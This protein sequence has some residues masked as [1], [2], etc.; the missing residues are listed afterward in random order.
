M[1]TREYIPSS[2]L[3]PSFVLR[4]QHAELS[5]VQF[6]D[7][8]P[9]L[10]TGSVEGSVWMWNVETRRVMHQF[11]PHGR[12]GMLTVQFMEQGNKMKVITQGRD[13]KIK[14]WD[15]EKMIEEK[16]VEGKRREEKLH[17][18]EKKA[19]IECSVM[20]RL[21]METTPLVTTIQPLS[22]IHSGCCSFC[23]FS[24][25]QLKSDLMP[26]TTNSPCFENNSNNVIRSEEI[27]SKTADSSKS[28]LSIALSQRHQPT[29]VKATPIA[30]LAS[31]SLLAVPGENACDINIW[32]LKSGK[33][34]IRCSIDQSNI[35][36][37]MCMSVKMIETSRGFPIISAGYESGHIASFQLQ[38]ASEPIMIQQFHQE[39]C[40]CIDVAEKDG[41]VSTASG[42][43]DQSMFLFEQNLQQF[44]FKNIKETKLVVAGIASLQFRP[45]MKIFVTGGWDH[46]CYFLFVVFLIQSAF[47]GRKNR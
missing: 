9:L 28:L 3:F 2:C 21:R 39:P 30:P 45:D 11:R 32:D 8:A 33:I 17:G 22:V 25:L 31:E 26:L 41:I 43:A 38:N 44:T 36:T 35:K 14:I 24:L 15:M 20:H 23:P 47:M 16:E 5:S 46:R 34:A 18:D 29:S 7:I 12:E 40:L 27:I 19:I 13:E 1:K 37:G 42:S 6:H 10:L 4:G